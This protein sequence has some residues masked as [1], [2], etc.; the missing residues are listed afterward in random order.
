MAIKEK[1]I[2]KIFKRKDSNEISLLKKRLS[3]NF[4]NGKISTKVF[5]KKKKKVIVKLF[6]RKDSI[7]ICLLKKRLLWNF[8]KAN[9]PLEYVYYRKGYCETF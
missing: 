8:L 6:K 7:E 9:I 4:L 1:V 3:W 5:F 2:V